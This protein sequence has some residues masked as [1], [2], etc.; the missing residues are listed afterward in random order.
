MPIRSWSDMPKGMRNEEV[1]YY[2]RKLLRKKSELKIKFAA[3]KILAAVLLL[4]FAIPMCIVAVMIKLDS[5]G[6]VFFRQKRITAYGRIFR[7]HK[8]RT[9]VSDADKKGSSVTVKGDSRI[10][11]VG[12]FI[13]KYR[14]D[15]L[16]QLIDVLEGNMSFVGTRPE[17]PEY[18][19]KYT[20][21]MRA[22]LLLPAGITSRASIEYKDE[23]DILDG[24][25]DPDK[26]YIEKILP[27]KMK[28]NLESIERF[29]LIGDMKVMLDTVAAVLH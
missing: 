26:V 8:F 28:Y 7:I 24:V 21:P 13:R 16:P 23:A 18:V 19:R 9:M 15:E 1:L 14:I 11:K 29:S 27:E 2:Y 17:I 22:T 6:P 25:D 12:R 20:K 10:T 4:V 3:D 5:P